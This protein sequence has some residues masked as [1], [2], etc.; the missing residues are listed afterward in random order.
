MQGASGCPL[1][2]AGRDSGR[3]IKVE[4]QAK[5]SRLAPAQQI[6]HLPDLDSHSAVEILGDDTTGVLLIHS[7]V[8]VPMVH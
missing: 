6:Q 2:W 8:D 1:P 7:T 3:R 4:S 5:A